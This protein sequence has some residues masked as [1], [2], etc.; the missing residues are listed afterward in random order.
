MNNQKFGY[1][2]D[3]ILVVAAV[4]HIYIHPKSPGF[5]SSLLKFIRRTYPFIM[6]LNMPYHESR[7]T[8]KKSKEK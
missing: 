3:I 5:Q 6:L 4:G 1:I 8:A 7:M 2:Q